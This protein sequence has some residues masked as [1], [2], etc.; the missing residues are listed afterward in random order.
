MG[1][2][3]ILHYLFELQTSMLIQS[4]KRQTLESMSVHCGSQGHA[5]GLCLSQVKNWKTRLVL[6]TLL[7]ST[8]AVVHTSLILR[9]EFV[10]KKSLVLVGEVASQGAIFWGLFLMLQTIFRNCHVPFWS[11]QARSDGASDVKWFLSPCRGYD[12]GLLQMKLAGTKQ[13]REF[14]PPVKHQGSFLFF[15]STPSPK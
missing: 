12:A 1:T 3:N 9:H 5:N 8:L 15:T 14:V 4:L 10:F 2:S 13:Q 11:F 7:V 6:R